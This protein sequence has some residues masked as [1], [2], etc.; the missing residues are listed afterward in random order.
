MRNSS[1]CVNTHQFHHCAVDAIKGDDNVRLRERYDEGAKA[2]VRVDSQ[3]WRPLRSFTLKKS[4][5]VFKPRTW[6][7]MAAELNKSAEQAT[8]IKGVFD[9]DAFGGASAKASASRAKRKAAAAK[10]PKGKG[11]EQPSRRASKRARS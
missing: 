5:V 7:Q 9:E 4:K 6:K 1:T 2:L 3:Y 10:G 11:S 8:G